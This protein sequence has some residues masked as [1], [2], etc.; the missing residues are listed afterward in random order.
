LVC[1]AVNRVFLRD[2]SLS[3]DAVSSMRTKPL[4]CR[5]YDR[6]SR[7]QLERDSYEDSE[8]DGLM[9]EGD[10]FFPEESEEDS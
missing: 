2:A 7:K 1:G 6:E 3:F 8:G 9:G 10:I 5:T 4:R